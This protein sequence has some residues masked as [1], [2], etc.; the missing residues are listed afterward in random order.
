MGGE[1]I[2]FGFANSIKI[3]TYLNVHFNSDWLTIAGSGIKT[4]PLDAFHG[5]F[6]QAHAQR[7]LQPDP[8]NFSGFVNNDV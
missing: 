3:E 8:G 4:P 7:S 2:A 5:V 6:I 1:F